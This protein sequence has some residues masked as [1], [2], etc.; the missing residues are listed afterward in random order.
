LYTAIYTA[1]ASASR[2]S[3]STGHIGL[4]AQ[5][6][7]T[8][9]VVPLTIKTS[10]GYSGDVI[11][12]VDSSGAKTFSIGTTGTIVKQSGTFDIQH[13]LLST[14]PTK[15]LRHSFVESPLIDN[16]YSGTVQFAENKTAVVHIDE[17]F[18]MS[19]GTYVALTA[20]TRVIVSCNGC[21]ADWCIIGA[22][23]TITCTYFCDS[24]T[25]Q[26]SYRIIA[27]RADIGVLHMILLMTQGT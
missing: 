27:E 25:A 6:S 13:P 11:Q 16:L 20:N 22:V 19:A 7:L 3:Y 23:L 5:A 17:Q 15:R 21:L 4:T 9:S 24:T 12:A 10:T 1:L 26:A 8:T 2:A 18:N 14:Q